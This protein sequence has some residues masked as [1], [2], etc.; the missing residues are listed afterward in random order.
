MKRKLFI[1]YTGD[2][3]VDLD[4]RIVEFCE[5]LRFEETDRYHQRL[6][7]RRSMYFTFSYVGK[8]ESDFK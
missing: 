7:S 8:H 1:R 5:G 6:H 3:N 4:R 2:R